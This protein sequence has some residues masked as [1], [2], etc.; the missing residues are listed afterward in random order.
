MHIIFNIYL[1]NTM[2]SKLLVT[3]IS[4]SE[5]L[6]TSGIFL[7]PVMKVLNLN[8]NDNT[9]RVFNDWMVNEPG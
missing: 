8:H 7:L 9:K 5:F 3:V 4:A 6:Y 2:V 1:I